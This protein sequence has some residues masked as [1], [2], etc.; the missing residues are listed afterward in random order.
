VNIPEELK[1]KAFKQHLVSFK[2]GWYWYRFMPCMLVN[3]Q[4]VQHGYI[5]SER[6]AGNVAVVLFKY[7]YQISISAEV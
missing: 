5:S 3:N 6:L 7:V 4:S 1:L 2:S